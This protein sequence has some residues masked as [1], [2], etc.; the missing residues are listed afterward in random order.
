MMRMSIL[1][2]CLCYLEGYPSGAARQ[3]FLRARGQRRRRLNTCRFDGLST[4]RNCA[5]DLRVKCAV[6]V[7]VL[8]STTCIAAAQN[9]APQNSVPKG[10]PAIA[11]PEVPPRRRSGPNPP[12]PRRGRC[13]SSFRNNSRRRRKNMR[14]FR[15]K[16]PRPQRQSRPPARSDLAK[17]AEFKP[18]PVL[19]GAGRMRRHRRRAHGRRSS[20]PIRAR[21][22]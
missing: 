18:L 3:T 21:S 2:T 20:C 9:G 13:L 17:I 1:G 7:A 16:P 15:T 5:G 11:A 10:T 6:V 8:L 12:E 22:R 14:R 19:V 4:G